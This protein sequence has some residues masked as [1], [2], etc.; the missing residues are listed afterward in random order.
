MAPTT[1]VAHHDPEPHPVARLIDALVL[2][3]VSQLAPLHLG[4]VSHIRQPG[5]SGI[6]ER[7]HKGRLLH[8]LI[9]APLVIVAQ[10]PLHILGDQRQL[11]LSEVTGRF[12]IGLNAGNHPVEALP[13]ELLCLL[14]LLLQFGNE[15][16]IPFLTFVHGCYSSAKSLSGPAS[17][18]TDAGGCCRRRIWVFYC[19]FPA[20]LSIHFTDPDVTNARAIRSPINRTSSAEALGCQ[21]NLQ[22]RGKSRQREVLLPLHVPLSVWSS[23]HGARSQLHHR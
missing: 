11:V 19:D 17:G 21:E 20:D 16:F 14:P 12:Q 13:L 1:L 9:L 7:Q 4:A 2:Q 10:I 18:L 8:L 3:L 15:G 22:G 5:P 6:F 23:T